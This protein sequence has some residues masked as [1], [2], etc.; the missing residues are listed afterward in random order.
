[1]AP[2]EQSE[3]ATEERP[4]VVSRRVSEVDKKIQSQS[5]ERSLDGLML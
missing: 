4:P 2:Q 5:H 3:Q 1:M